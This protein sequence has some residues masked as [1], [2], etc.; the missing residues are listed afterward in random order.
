[1]SLDYFAKHL[2]D[3]KESTQLKAIQKNDEL[4]AQ[5][6]REIRLSS[7]SEHIANLG[8]QLLGKEIFSNS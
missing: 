3:M 6:N 5:Q 2:K 4:I 8:H 1:M 7:E